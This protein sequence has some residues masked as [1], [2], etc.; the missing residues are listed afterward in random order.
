MATSAVL[1]DG[2]DA[3]EWIGNDRQAAEVPADASRIEQVGP[4]RFSLDHGGGLGPMTGIVPAQRGVTGLVFRDGPNL[5]VTRNPGRA[6]PDLCRLA[7][8]LPV[9]FIHPARFLA[10]WGSRKSP[11]AGPPP[12]GTPQDVED[13]LAFCGSPSILIEAV[14][15]PANHQPRPEAVV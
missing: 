2:D 15:R 4:Y 12:V 9:W 10:C 1:R 13:L 6:N 7:P 11:A 14:Q 8:A 3:E 5:G